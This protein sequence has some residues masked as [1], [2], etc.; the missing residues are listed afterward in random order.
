MKNVNTA[1]QN[2]DEVSPEE[3]DMWQIYLDEQFP[4]DNGVIKNPAELEVIPSGLDAMTNSMKNSDVVTKLTFEIDTSLT[5]E[6]SQTL[7]FIKNLRFLAL[8]S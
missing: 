3:F 1:I 5:N 7:L 6:V 4:L 8:V 2:T